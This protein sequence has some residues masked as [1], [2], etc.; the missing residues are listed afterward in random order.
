MKSIE[1]EA[2][3][4]KHCIRLPEAILDGIHLRVLLLMDDGSAS[5]VRSNDSAGDH[6]SLHRS[7]VR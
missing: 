3:A 7:S 4:A 6:L 5:S 2:T 1:F